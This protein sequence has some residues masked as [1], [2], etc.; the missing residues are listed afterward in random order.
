MSKSR[1][2][3][4]EVQEVFDRLHTSE[5]GLSS[6]EARRRFDEVGPN[7]LDSALIFL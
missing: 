7:V 5:K 6:E 1:W 3:T 2:E 4:L